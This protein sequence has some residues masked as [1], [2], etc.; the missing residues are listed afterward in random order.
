MSKTTKSSSEVL[1]NVSNTLL[2]QRKSN[3]SGFFMDC[4]IESPTSINPL[5]HTIHFLWHTV[6]CLAAYNMVSVVPGK[7]Y[8]PVTVQLCPL[9][10]SPGCSWQLPM[11]LRSDMGI[12][13]ELK[14]MAM[15][16]L[17]PGE[18]HPGGRKSKILNSPLGMLFSLRH[19]DIH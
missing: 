10:Y 9:G 1:T 2:C 18:R 7:S 11:R 15:L 8:C 12:L 3:N 13:M 17:P 14:P 16:Q 6:T 5:S 4:G 19:K